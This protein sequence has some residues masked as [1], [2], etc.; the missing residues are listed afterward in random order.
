VRG[1]R[2]EAGIKSYEDLEV[3]QEGYRLIIEI[4]K[5]AK[6]FPEEERYGLR[7]QLKRA[8]LSI[9]LNIAEGYGRKAR[10]A[11]FKHFLRNALGSSNEVIVLLKLVKDL[12]LGKS[13]TL[14]EEYEKLAKRLYRLEERW[15]AKEE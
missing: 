15:E 6:E 1:E 2:R 14:I 8:A 4:Y 11:E 12:G 9:P 10:V 3:Y 13:E 7:G 5:I